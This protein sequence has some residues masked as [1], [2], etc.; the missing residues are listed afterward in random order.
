M[1]TFYTGYAYD[2]R[3]VVDLDAAL[4]GKGTL[5]STGDVEGWR[6]L[7]LD[8]GKAILPTGMLMADG[9]YEYPIAILKADDLLVIA[10]QHKKVVDYLRF[11]QLGRVFKPTVRRAIIDIDL[12]VDHLLEWSAVEASAH[13]EP[14][15]YVMS[16]VHAQTIA[17]EPQLK[18]TMFYGDDIGEAGL[19]RRIR[20]LLRCA[21]CGVRRSDGPEVLRIG[22]DG[23]VSFAL[24]SRGRVIRLRLAA[25]AIDYVRRRG[26][27]RYRDDDAHN[28]G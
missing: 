24:P 16:Y 8:T 9:P 20:P 27:L 2:G 28:R 3:S 17:F 21:V 1:L 19:F 5:R 22:T 13:D 23:S 7:I 12:L 25:E 10:A 15:P 18:S 4:A 11:V 14:P 26:F 6:T